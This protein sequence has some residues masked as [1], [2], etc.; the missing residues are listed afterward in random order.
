MSAGRQN[1]DGGHGVVCLVLQLGK[2]FELYATG[3][4]LP[5]PQY[6]FGTTSEQ[7]S[8]QNG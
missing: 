5:F 2:A 7:S 8:E 3:S 4:L 1:Y 6:D